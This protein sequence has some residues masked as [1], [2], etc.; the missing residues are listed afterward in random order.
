MGIFDSVSGMQP[1]IGTQQ[2]QGLLGSVAG[3]AG[4]A[5]MQQAANP[6]G[7]QMATSLSQN[8]T[9]QM[10]QQIIQQLKTSGNP[11]AAQYEQILGGLGSDP[12]QIKQ[13]ADSM[14]QHFSGAQQ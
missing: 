9:P 7:A 8:P 12:A 13:F 4:P 1:S 2:P 6:Q 3:A 11:Q 5:P 10:V 14:V